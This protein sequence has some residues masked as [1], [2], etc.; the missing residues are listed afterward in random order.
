MPA[1]SKATATLGAL[2]RGAVP[3]LIAAIALS[4]PA[5][6][7]ASSAPSVNGVYASGTTVSSSLLTG[8]VDP[9]GVP[10]S[11]YFQYGTTTAYGAQTPTES[12]GSGSSEV[13]VSAAIGEL[14]GGVTYHFRLVAASA[15]GTTVG[16]DHIFTT[17]VVPLS[18]QL[19]ALP[20]P[21]LA[22]ESLEVE[23][24]L[25]G[26]NSANRELELQMN[27][28]PYS[29]GMARTG[30]PTLTDGSGHF[31]FQG[32][33]LL[34]NTHFRVAT[35][36]A[37]HVSSPTIAEQV[38]VRVAMQARRV[39]RRGH[40]TFFRLYGTV[41]PADVGADVAFVV[42]RGGKPSAVVGATRVKRASVTVSR[43]SAIVR[44]RRGGLYE[45]IVTGPGSRNAPGYSVPVRVR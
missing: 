31:S 41:W 18:F 16:P 8:Y 37:P 42:V 2:R 4:L 30:L 35:V 40:R 27:P 26:S 12:A 6:V 20:N 1:S 19:S 24:T 32:L 34:E 13:R 33:S 3:A 28:F 7:S 38:A 14:A 43:F 5:S 25:S 23:G 15:A 22:G 21:V 17:K 9:R 45:A 10:T 11:Y 36:A 29:F 39:H 44:I